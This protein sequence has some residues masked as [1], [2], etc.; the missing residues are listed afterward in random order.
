MQ[1][2]FPE[3]LEHPQGLTP[4]ASKQK[5]QNNYFRAWGNISLNFDSTAAS[6]NV[7]LLLWTHQV[8]NE[9]KCW[10][11]AELNF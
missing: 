4:L 10:R 8:Y 6:A 1:F 5:F 3:S 2:C 9:F 7:D 11:V